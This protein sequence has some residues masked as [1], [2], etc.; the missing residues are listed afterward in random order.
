MHVNSAAGLLREVF[1]QM[2][3]S[4]SRRHHAT[5]SA[6]VRPVEITTGPAPSRSRRRRRSATVQG[7]NSLGIS[8]SGQ[9]GRRTRSQGN[10]V[11]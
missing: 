8:S 3:E 9:I 2:T 6:P 4:R 5:S 1:E 7:V 11:A 10:V